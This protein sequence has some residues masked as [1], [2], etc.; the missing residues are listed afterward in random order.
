VLKLDSSGNIQWQKHY[1]AS[2]NASPQSIHQTSDLGYALV[3]GVGQIGNIDMWMLKLD[4]SGNIQWQKAFAGGSSDFAEAIRSDLDGGYIIAGYTESFGAG[5]FDLWVMK[6]DANGNVDSA[7]SFVNPIS[8]TSTDGSLLVQDTVLGSV[9][10]TSVPS[11]TNA[12]VASGSP[13]VEKQCGNEPPAANNDF[14]IT[15]EDVSVTIDVLA[16]D[17]DPD[18]EPLDV[19]GT[20]Q[21]ANGTVINNGD[22]TI[23]YTPN[24]NFNGPDSY[25]YTITDGQV[26][27]T[28]IVSVTVVTGNDPPSALNDNAT[29]SENTPIAIDVLSNDSDPDGSPIGVIAVT[30][31]TNGTVTN[32]GDGTATYTPASG[33]SGV[34]SFNYT[35]SDGQFKDT[36]TVNITVTA[37]NNC[38]LCDDFENGVLDTNWIYNKS[39]SSWSE[40]GGNLTVTTNAKSSTVAGSFPGC[41][42]CTVTATMQTAGGFGNRVWLLHHFVDRKSFVELMMKEE[43]NLWVLKVRQN[44]T[45]IAKGKVLRAIDPN[46]IYQASIVY[47]G[48]QYQAFVDG[49][50]VI[51]LDVASPVGNGTSG[52]KVKRTTG[53]F[54]YIEVLP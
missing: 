47:N 34:D 37:I 32:N 40:S 35:I 50:L 1:S 6:T 53:Q 49:K 3:G 15:S 38:L 25:S 8:F 41:S 30:Q 42:I 2:E 24:T 43:S 46:V 13:I 19:I 12:I 4:P 14:A 31:G 27:A 45:I 52:F 48:T 54:G 29:T 18:N 10:T 7:C 5:S 44:K 22:G 28:A 17:T 51:A 26:I 33:F 36:A 16:N 23:A 11:A 21:P 9:T 20:T 39:I